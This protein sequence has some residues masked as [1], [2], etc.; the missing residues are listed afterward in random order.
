MSKRSSHKHQ[1]LTIIKRNNILDAARHL[2]GLV[3]DVAINVSI[4]LS[5]GGLGRVD[6]A[7]AAVVIVEALVVHRGTLLVQ[8]HRVHV[9]RAECLVQL[10]KSNALRGAQRL[11]FA[12]D[13]GGWWWWWW[14]RERKIQRD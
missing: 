10:D 7:A 5:A 8:P 9:Q 3:D 11:C 1:P 14:K 2:G 13:D 6:V 12:G 4:V